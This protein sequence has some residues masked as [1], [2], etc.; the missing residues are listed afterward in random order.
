MKHTFHISTNQRIIPDEIKITSVTSGFKT[1][2]SEDISIYKLVS[3]WP[4]VSKTLA[5][6]CIACNRLLFTL[7]IIRKMDC[8]APQNKSLHW[9]VK[10]ANCLMKG[11]CFS[12]S[13]KNMYGRIM[14]E[15]TYWLSDVE[16]YKEKYL[17]AKERT[18]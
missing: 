13:K 2:K 1:E 9:H 4:C 11:I 7:I 6:Q 14:S 12:R 16:Y 10:S 3:S 15:N 17:R 5:K 8:W 18:I